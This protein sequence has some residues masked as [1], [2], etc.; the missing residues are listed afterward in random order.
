MKEREQELYRQKKKRKDENY[1][2]EDKGSKDR[3]RL[4]KEKIKEKRIV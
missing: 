2:N 3:I 1:I 4:E